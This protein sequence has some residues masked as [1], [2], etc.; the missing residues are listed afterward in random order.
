MKELRD[1]KIT[2]VSVEEGGM[3]A[4]MEFDDG[5][6][7]YWGHGRAAFP[8]LLVRPNGDKFRVQGLW[9][10]QDESEN[11]PDDDGAMMIPD[12]LHARFSSNKSG[13]G[14]YGK[15]RPGKFAANTAIDSEY[16]EKHI[17]NGE[18]GYEVSVY[19][20]IDANDLKKVIHEYDGPTPWE[21]WEKTGLWEKFNK[22][23]VPT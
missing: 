15:V 6:E 4:Y 16:P 19:D 14:Y 2:K 1:L 5:T 20:Y 9:W 21:D 18:P 17:V 22:A 23:N 10:P 3:Y 13:W 11:D 12:E 8:N 7:L